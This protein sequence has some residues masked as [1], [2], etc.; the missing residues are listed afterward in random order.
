MTRQPLRRHQA[1]R[2]DPAKLRP[3][4]PDWIRAAAA[5]VAIDLENVAARYPHLSPATRARIVRGIEKF[6]QG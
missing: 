1:E 3:L 4:A 6:K 2:I 5:E